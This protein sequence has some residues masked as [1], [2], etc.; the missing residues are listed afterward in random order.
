VLLVLRLE[1]FVLVRP[2]RDVQCCL[3]CVYMRESFM[4][5]DSEVTKSYRY[6]LQSLGNPPSKVDP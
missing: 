2:L 1:I 3:C 5:I 4:T 6:S